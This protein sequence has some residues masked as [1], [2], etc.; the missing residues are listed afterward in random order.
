VPFAEKP[1]WMEFAFQGIGVMAGVVGWFFAMLLYKD[2]KSTVPATLKAR[3]EGIWTVVY[4]KYYVDELYAAIVVRPSVG[5]ARVFSKFDGTVIDGVVNLAGWIGRQL[6]AID[7]AIDKYVVDGLVNAV[8]NATIGMGRAFRNV[9]TGR[10]QTYLYGALGGALVV[11]L[12]NFL[13]Q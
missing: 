13:I 1:R 8:A 11:V 9:Q 2:A 10:I 12:L 6:G 7:A 4:N 5:V 3:F